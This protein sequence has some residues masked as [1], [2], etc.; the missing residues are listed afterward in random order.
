MKILSTLLLAFTFETMLFVHCAEAHVWPVLVAGA[1][2]SS[3]GYYQTVQ[4]A[5]TAINTY[6]QTDNIIS[7]TIS[8]STT[9]TVS[10]VLNAGAWTSMSIYPTAPSV[11]IGGDIAGPVIDLDGASNVTID[12]REGAAGSSVGMTISNTST[13]STLGTSAV[14]FINGASN[15]TVKYCSLQG[16]S[17]ALWPDNGIVVLSTSG[18]STGNNGNALTNNNFTS[19]GGNR[20]LCAIASNGTVTRENSGNS[21][22]G[23]NFYDFMNFAG[24]ST[25]G[26]NIYA[27]STGCTIQG[28]SFYETLPLVPAANATAFFINLV[29][30]QN[31]TVSGNYFGGSAASCGGTALTKTNAMNNKLCGINVAVG[32]ATTTLSGNTMQNIFWSNPPDA[33]VVGIFLGAAANNCTITGNTIGAASGTA[34]LTLEGT[35]GLFIGI[36]AQGS[37]L[38]GPL[39][40]SHNTIGAIASTDMDVCGITYNRAQDVGTVSDNFILNL[41][42]GAA[43]TTY[44][45]IAMQGTPTWSN[46]II[47]LSGNSSNTLYGIYDMGGTNSFFFNTVY[48]GGAPTPNSNMSLA[49]YSTAENTRNYRNNIFVNA[50]SNSLSLNYAIAI[51]FG[52]TLTI[53]SNDYY[54]SGAGGML[55]NYVG[56]DISDIAGWKTAVPQDAGSVITAPSF[57]GAGGSLAANYSL[58]VALD[59]IA[60]TGVTTDYS[61]FA[62]PATPTMG[63]IE[64]TNPLPVE[65]TAFTAAVERGSVLLRWTTATEV[66]NHG[67]ETQRKVRNGSSTVEAW[68]TIGFV[69]GG[70]TRNAPQSYRFSDSKVFGT[71]VYRLKQIDRDGTCEYSHEVEVTAAAAP[72]EFVLM[73]N[74]PNP[75]NPT[76]NIMFTVPAD[77]HATLKI[78][79]TIGQE[80]ATLFNGEAVAGTYHQVHFNAS[81]LASGVYFSRLEY[82]GKVQLKKLILQ[83]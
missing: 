63:A 82:N 48:I 16:S 49:M 25:A 44:G 37:A 58:G 20:P 75:F 42:G 70:G 3:N 9:E 30:G 11:V 64:K 15:N 77:G 45:I 46:N 1:H 79:N 31:H 83:K 51:N 81:G 61:G 35:D 43:S 71:V 28:N 19:A 7:L 5:V 47:S 62:R 10:S 14:R 22:I 76:T 78:F 8:A 55:G 27:N 38:S 2:S 17:T 80:V 39:L 23:N 41:S 33:V 60:G 29:C 12:G 54:V 32:T 40:I 6:V 56:A 65:L 57:S 52:T 18:G 4:E 69:E 74:Y 13:S 36:F 72:A 24:S 73:Q 50:R 26:I 66:N 59:G 67:F 34:S 68:Q 53:N 21:I